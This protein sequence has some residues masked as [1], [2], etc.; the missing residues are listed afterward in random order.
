[1]AEGLALAASVIAVL[2][3]T[4]TV[5]SVCYDYSATAKGAS[6]QLVRIRS[7]LE[8]LRNVLQQLEPLA[9]QAELVS[10]TEP[11]TETK[12]PAFA[13]LCGPEGLLHYCLTEVK[14]LE[15]R[16]K[17]PSWCDGFGPKR[18]AL[19][20]VLQWPMKEADTEKKLKQIARLKDSLILALNADQT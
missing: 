12:L 6:S 10:P 2:Q 9:K 14:E 13:Q 7:E 1:M 15:H 16:L 4:N 17:T 3:I 20:Q 8:S 18:R 19:V 11:A 5:I